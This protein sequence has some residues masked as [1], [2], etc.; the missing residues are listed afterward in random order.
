MVGP[1]SRGV[2]IMGGTS[3]WLAEARA[4]E[5][6]GVCDVATPPEGRA[7][8]TPEDVVAMVD[9]E[10][11]EMVAGVGIKHVWDDGRT[12]V[13]FDLT[14]FLGDE[15]RQT[16]DVESGARAMFDDLHQSY[17]LLLRPRGGEGDEH[18]FG[19][20]SCTVAGTELDQLAEAFDRL[21]RSLRA[22][23]MLHGHW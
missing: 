15:A 4:G 9:R 2:V 22:R 14:P 16:G 7:G 6:E 21:E 19:H 3:A 18:D 8:P 1:T 10:V 13:T 20:F 23:K 11:A 17:G 5:A 12:V